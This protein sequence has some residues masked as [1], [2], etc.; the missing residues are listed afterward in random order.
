MDYSKNK[1][2]IIVLLGPTAVGKTELSL[3]LADKLPGEIISADS[4]QVYK[5]MDI[6]TAK[7]KNKI[8]EKIPHYLID[9]ISPEEEFSV[10]EY[11]ERVDQ[12]IPQ[13]IDNNSF[14]MLVGGTGMYI[15]A[16]IEGF[17]LPEIEP[18]Q[19][20]R[21]QLKNEAED[22]GRKYVH[23]KLA[24]IDPELANKLHPND[25]RR[26]IRGIEIYKQ[27]G[28]TKTYYK[29][30]QKERPPRYKS[31]KF[32]LYRERDELYNII[33]RR[34]DNMIKKGLVDEV[35]MLYNNFNLSKTACQ[36][37]GYKEIIGYIEGKY[38][39]K[40]AIRQIK[41]NTRNFAK[42]QLSYFKRDDDI[43]WFNLTK[44]NYRVVEEKIV[45]IIKG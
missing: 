13:I 33:N 16:V 3:E 38:D 42:R 21:N 12:I 20:L 10:A 9:I 30:R 15:N 8:R 44:M 35:E 11:Q 40:E 4:M 22:K 27:T 7:V 39:K 32:G 24:D 17:M 18:D 26:V 37:L 31:L 29:N 25:L 28:H 34:V 6:G 1:K 19:E 45:K 5:N 36:A 14:P 23:N 43:R 2:A 41:K